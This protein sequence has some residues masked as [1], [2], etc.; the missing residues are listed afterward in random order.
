MTDAVDEIALLQAWRDGDARAGSAL[1]AS[2]FPLVFRFFASKLDRAAEDLA[3]QTFET[4]VGSRERIP[5]H[6]GLRAWV[7]SVARHHLL[8]E[9]RRRARHELRFDPLET[10]VAGLLG[11]PSAAVAVHEHQQRVMQALRTLPID[12]QAALELY[13]WEDMDVAQIAFALGVEPGTVRSRLFR[14]RRQ[15]ARALALPEDD[16]DQTEAS[17]RAGRSDRTSI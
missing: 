9:L 6:A 13:Y 12:F 7:I 4:C 16:D 3:Q 14:G 11:S 17:L 10:T 8:H 1:V 2:L 15:L 5:A